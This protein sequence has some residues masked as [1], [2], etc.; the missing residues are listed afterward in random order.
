MFKGKPG[1]GNKNRQVKASKYHPRVKVIFNE[2]AYANSSNFID[3]IRQDY[4]KA[5]V[6]PFTDHE[7]RLLVLDAF[8][9]YK[10]SGR[11]I[12]EKETVAQKAKRLREK[13]LNNIIRAE[14]KK[15]NVT[16]F[17]IPRGCIGYV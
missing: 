8:A 7:P 9:P 6:Y 1:K 2:K 3:W 5:L 15:L 13:Q 16:L 10:H 12:P 11:K 4:S 17:L 14:F